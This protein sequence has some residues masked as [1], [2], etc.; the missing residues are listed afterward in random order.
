[1]HRI[2]QLERENSVSTHVLELLPQLIR[3]QPK[4]GYRYYNLT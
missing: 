2:P 3:G 4:I 1:M